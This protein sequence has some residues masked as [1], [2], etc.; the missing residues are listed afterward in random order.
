MIQSHILI[1]ACLRFE[2]EYIY[3]QLWTKWTQVDHSGPKWTK[4]DKIVQKWTQVNPN[5]PRLTQVDQIGPKWTLSDP[6]SAKRSLADWAWIPS[7]TCNLSVLLWAILSV[8][9]ASTELC[10]LVL[11]SESLCCSHLHSYYKGDRGTLVLSKIHTN[12]SQISNKPT[13]CSVPTNLTRRSFYF[14]L[15]AIVLNF[16]ETLLSPILLW[17]LPSSSGYV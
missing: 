17:Y 10:E 13:C 3:R 15:K 9:I 11:C 14:V 8:A 6:C 1:Y 4:V 16:H 5:R 7:S 12:V 2:I